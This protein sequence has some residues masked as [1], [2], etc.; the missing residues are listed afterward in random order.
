MIASVLSWYV[1]LFQT[2]LVHKYKFL[3]LVFKR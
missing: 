1:P 3:T 2:F